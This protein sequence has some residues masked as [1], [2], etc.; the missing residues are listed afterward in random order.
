LAN[1]DDWKKLQGAN[2][3]DPG[4]AAKNQLKAMNDNLNELQNLRNDILNAMKVQ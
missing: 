2:P 1:F 3:F 4:I